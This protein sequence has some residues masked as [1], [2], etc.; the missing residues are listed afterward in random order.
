MDS[1]LELGRYVFDEK[2]EI[3][4]QWTSIGEKKYISSF[5][6][7]ESVR[8]DRLPFAEDYEGSCLE[9]EINKLVIRTGLKQQGVSIRAA[10]LKDIIELGIGSRAEAQGTLFHSPYICLQNEEY[11]LANRVGEKALY[12]DKQ[13][14]IQSASVLTKKYI[15]LVMEWQED[16]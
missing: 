14:H 15:R 5:L 13:G 10:T 11:W 7:G 4:M 3:P 2:L 1:D 12:V 16:I 9:E 6:I 8:Y